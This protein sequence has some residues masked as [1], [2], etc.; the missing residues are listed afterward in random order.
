MS[1]NGGG[2]NTISIMFESILDGNFIPRMDTVLY[3]PASLII[4]PLKVQQFQ[5]KLCNNI[6]SCA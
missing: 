5:A 1:I 6:E 3:N 4:W 2:I